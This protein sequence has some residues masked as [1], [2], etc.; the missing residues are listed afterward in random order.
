LTSLVSFGGLWW[1]IN[2]YVLKARGTVDQCHKAKPPINVKRR[3]DTYKKMI[4]SNTGE[5]NEPRIFKVSK[6]VWLPH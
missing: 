1:F 6:K 5:L 2:A 4:S 3:S